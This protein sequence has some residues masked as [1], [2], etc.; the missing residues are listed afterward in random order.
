MQVETRHADETLVLAPVGDWTLASPL[1]DVQAVVVNAAPSSP[2]TAIAFDTSELGDWDSSLVTFL[3]EVADYGRAHGLEVQTGTLPAALERLVALSQAVPEEDTTPEAE[4]TSLLARLGHWG[5][6]AYDEAHALVTFLGRAVRSVGAVL[7][8]QGR[9]RWRAFG[10]ALQAS[11]ASAL[12]IV[13]VISLLVGLIVAFLGAVVLQRF[14]ADYFVSYLVSYGML[15]ELG[16][17]MTAIIMTG[18]T[19][20]A[21]A[22]ELGSMKV[23]EEI[24]ALETFG[25]SPID[26]LVTPRILAVVLALPMLTLYADALGILGGMGVAV[27]MLDLTTTQF[28]MGL[29]EPVVLS[30]ALVGIFKAVVYGG[31]IGLAG[32][33]RGLHT[34]DDASAVGQATTS[35]VVTGILLIV[36][37]NAIIDWA[38]AVLQ[39]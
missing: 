14:G 39:F 32:C 7:T 21:F 25:I 26:F 9:M 28:L 24:D 5:L 18:R 29:L 20:A 17:L 23:N 30:D 33:M 34:G 38:A 3:F 31:I 4:D 16:A 1:P 19:G 2:V 22:A 27:T 13:T 10:E 36:F 12:P 11:T 37:A 35:A 6:A 15:R 8:G